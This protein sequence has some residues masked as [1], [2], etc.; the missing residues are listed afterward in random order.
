MHGW[1]ITF[2]ITMFSALSLSLSLSLID[3][4]KE[5]LCKHLIHVYWEK[6]SKLNL[7]NTSQL[8]NELVWKWYNYRGHRIN[9]S[10]D[11][12]NKEMYKKW[13]RKWLGTFRL[14]F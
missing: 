9:N 4:P 12:R 14:K 13:S 2:M 10:K 6:I 7:I 8:R 11:F 3:E 5:N 1:V